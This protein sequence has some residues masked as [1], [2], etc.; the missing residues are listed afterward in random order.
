M[1]AVEYEVHAWRG[2]AG[3]REQRMLFKQRDD[4]V[5]GWKPEDRPRSVKTGRTNDELCDAPRE[6][7]VPDA[8]WAVPTADDLAALDA[9]GRS[10]TWDLAGRELRLTTW[11]RRRSRHGIAAAPR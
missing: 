4:D 10:A 3:S 11:T 5:A 6:A 7:T 8:S 1:R 9:L 2:P